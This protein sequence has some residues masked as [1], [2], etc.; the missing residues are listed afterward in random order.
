MIGCQVGSRIRRAGE[1]TLGQTEQQSNPAPYVSRTDS[2]LLVSWKSFN[3]NE[4]I[5]HHP[6]IP[7]LSGSI[8]IYV[9][10]CF[11]VYPD[12]IGV[13]LR[14]NRSTPVARRCYHRGACLVPRHK[15]TITAFNSSLPLSTCSA[16]TSICKFA[17]AHSLP[18]CPS[19]KPLESLPKTK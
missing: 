10:P 1:I 12:S 3:P 13:S 14:C 6:P 2:T 19:Y 17:N 8:T 9:I 5:Y 4:W 15:R 18:S 11:L 7:R 16:C